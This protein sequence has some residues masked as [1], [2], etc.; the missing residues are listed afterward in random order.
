[1]LLTSH[2]APIQIGASRHS[3][4]ALETQGGML[5]QPQMM[6][7]WPVWHQ[8]LSSKAGEV[9][10]MMQEVANTHKVVA[11]GESHRGVEVGCRH[12]VAEVGC[13]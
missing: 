11:R 10:G 7:S 13:S 9:H 4:H 2:Y 12:G 1:M 5:E 8:A 3:A 6:L